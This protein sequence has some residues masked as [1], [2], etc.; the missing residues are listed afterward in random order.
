MP[1]HEKSPAD[2]TMP[3]DEL[4][5]PGAYL[6]NQKGKARLMEMGP[7]LFHL[8]VGLATNLLCSFSPPYAAAAP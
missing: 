6:L 5:I 8:A 2:L 3:A 4:I 7:V 1:F